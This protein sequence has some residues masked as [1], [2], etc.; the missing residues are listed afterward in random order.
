MLIKNKKSTRICTSNILNNN[1][2]KSKRSQDAMDV[3][4][5][6][7]VVSAFFAIMFTAVSIAGSGSQIKEKTFARQIALAIDEIKPGSEITLYLP[8]LFDAAAKNKY[9]NDVVFPDYD[10]GK[11]TVHIISGEGNSYYFF[12]K[13]PAGALSVNKQEKTVIIRL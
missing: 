7:I 5:Y 1:L 2:V 8:D 11:I 12:T 13:L 6:L 9:N 3:A 4:V 10:A